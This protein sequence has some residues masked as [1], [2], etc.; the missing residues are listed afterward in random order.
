MNITSSTAYFGG[1]CFWCTE[2]IFLSLKGVI[3]TMPGYIN[4][5]EV[6]KVDFAPEI[7]SFEDL[8]AVFFY[9]HDPTTRNRQGNDIGPQYQSSIFYTD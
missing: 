9:T 4:G 5:V 3:S 6:T 8:L 7:I 1:G 2:A